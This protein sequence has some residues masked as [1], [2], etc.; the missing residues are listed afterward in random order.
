MN[1]ELLDELSNFLRVSFLLFHSIIFYYIAFWRI[2]VEQET[3]RDFAIPFFIALVLNFTINLFVL[4]RNFL[5]EFYIIFISFNIAILAV[6][7]LYW[8]KKFLNLMVSYLFISILSAFLFPIIKNSTFIFLALFPIAL[9]FFHLIYKEKYTS[10]KP[11]ELL[12]NLIR[13]G[14]LLPF[15]FFA[16]YTLTLSLYLLTGSLLFNFFATAFIFFSLFTRIQASYSKRKMNFLFYISCF[17]ILFFLFF[18]FGTEFIQ[19]AKH[20]NESNKRLN[21]QRLVLE[22]KGK[23]DSYSNF[24]K[25][26]A[27]SND[28]KNEIEKGGEYLNSYLS[29]LNESLNTTI[30]IFANKKGIVTGCSKEYRDKLLNRDISFRSYYKESIE[31][32][33]SVFL[34][35]G[36]FTKREDI[37]ISYP[38][39]KSGDI[40][41]IIVFQFDI[42]ENFKEQIEIENAF[43]MHSSG[44]VLIGKKELM[45]RFILKPSEEELRKIEE[46][47]FFGIEKVEYSNIRQIDNN[48]FEFNNRKWQLLK[49]NITSEWYLASFMNLNIYENFKYILLFSLLFLSFISHLLF[50]K[51]LENIRLLFLSLA[52]EVESRRVSLDAMDTAVIYTNDKGKVTYINKEAAKLIQLQEKEALG[53]DIESIIT[54]KEHSIPEYKILNIHSKEIPIIF[55]KQA[56]LVDNINIGS[57]ITMKDATDIIRSHELQKRLER[58]DTITK[59]SSGIVH[60]FNNYLFAVT[61]NLSILRE[62]EKDEKKKTMIERMIEATKIMANTINEL[63]DLSPDFVAQKEK[64]DIVKIAKTC[65]D[66]I[67]N[68]SNIK[69]NLIVE[70]PVFPIYENQ[71]QIY[72]VFQNII[73]NAK[74]AM[75]DEG[76]IEIYIKGINNEGEIAEINRGK[77]VFVKITDSGPGIPEEYLDKIF[78]PFFTLKKEGKGLGLSIV[79][80]I[81]E[82]IEGKIKL[83]SEVGKGT[84]FKI[85]IPASD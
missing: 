34:A 47:K 57:V 13:E 82:K 60:D 59:I 50:T 66:L 43:V 9:S 4:F 48:L 64:L 14:L 42:S 53:R 5:G 2:K 70:E 63:K 29:Y 7:L 1:I 22:I 36:L 41:G 58:M 37:R 75:Q 73:V 26:I 20:I 18:Y 56:L 27:L 55:S 15:L 45:N 19:K 68:E 30:V 16:L 74:Q 32:K 6:L 33:L 31:G 84:T 17:N 65:I 25:I 52:E 62:M 80:N 72:R 81:I 23:V 40:I 69:F 85:Y 61:G 3:K 54:I 44:A 77:Y 11:S 38:V 71:A 83:E 8:Y 28:L 35:R 10:K 12:P 46:E 79:K 24:I 49:E 67:L 51:N 78:D 21:L 76:S 39:Y